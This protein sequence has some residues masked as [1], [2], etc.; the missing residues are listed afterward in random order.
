[1]K[2]PLFLFALMPAGLLFSACDKPPSTSDSQSAE[3]K[4][5]ASTPAPS[6]VAEAPVELDADQFLKSFGSAGPE[7][8]SRV[9]KA[10][11][12]IRAENFAAA[13][14]TLEHL[15]AQGHLTPEQKDLVTHYV[16]QLRKLKQTNR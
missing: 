16:T 13:L 1:M 4:S 3:A 2:L 6:V 5:A 12:A 15:L 11:Q 9:G 7:E 14:E 10:A 8:Q